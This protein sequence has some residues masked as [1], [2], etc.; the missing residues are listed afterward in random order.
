MADGRYTREEIFSQ[1]ESWAAGLRRLNEQRE[2]LLRFRDDG[3]YAQVIFTGC[4]STYY[5]AL[6]AAPWAQELWG[7][8]CRAFPA[9]ELWLH[10]RACYAD[11][12][13]LLVALSRSGETTETL[14]AC[15]AFLEDG[16]GDLLVLTCYPESPLAQLGKMTLVF[17]EAQERSVVQTRSFSTL[18][19]ATLVLTALWA[20]EEGLLEALKTLPGMA[21]ERLPRYVSLVAEIEGAGRSERFFWLGSGPRYGLACELSLKM[22]EMA[23]SPS[24]AFHFLE[25]R[26]GPKSVVGPGVLVVGLCSSTH[27]SYEKAVLQEVEALGGS[28]LALGEDPRIG[29]AP[30]L[31]EAARNVLYLPLGQ[32]L[33]L[34][35]ALSKG[36]DPDAPSHLEPVVRLR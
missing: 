34:E 11:G 26:H 32:L 22:K 16:R 33:A 8:P 5:L 4:G 12:R 15:Q 20:G 6:A 30:G 35:H 2:A 13:A 27:A 28:A 24:E 10:P 36:L 1:P 17:P 23:L 3:D 25:F 9:S 31:P 19:L 29:L 7:W 21:R 14:R 18:Y